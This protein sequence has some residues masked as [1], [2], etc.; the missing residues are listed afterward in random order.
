[1]EVIDVQCYAFL[2]EVQLKQKKIE[3]Y[4][5]LEIEELIDS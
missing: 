3:Q 2:G 1:V 4:L 5:Y